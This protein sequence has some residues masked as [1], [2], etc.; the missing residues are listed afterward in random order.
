M[1]T[2]DAASDAVV[3]LDE[4]FAR[5]VEDACSL[6]RTQMRKGTDVPVRGAPARGGGVGARGRGHAARGDCGAVPR[7]PR[8]HVGNAEADPQTV[9]TQS[10]A[11]RRRVHRRAGRQ[12]GE[13][14]EAATRRGQLA[15]AE[16]AL[17]RT[18]ERSAARRSPSSASAPPM[19]STT[20][21]RRSPISGATDPRPGGASTPVPSTSSGT[22]GRCRSCSRRRLPGLL[23]DELRVTVRELEKLA[24]WWFDLGDPQTGR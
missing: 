2:D 6:H 10:G 22:T 18:P 13:T 1:P 4:Q 21:A 7:L 15:R 17:A 23:S 9:R 8:G 12:V 16:D 20:R 5:A 11:H 19:P 14:E 24:G 3:V